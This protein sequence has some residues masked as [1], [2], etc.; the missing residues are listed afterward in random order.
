MVRYWTKAFVYACAVTNTDSEKRATFSR[1]LYQEHAMMQRLK[2]RTAF[3]FSFFL[4]SESE[5]WPAGALLWLGAIKRFHSVTHTH[6]CLSS[7]SDRRQNKEP[8]SDGKRFKSR[9]PCKSKAKWR[10]GVTRVRTAAVLITGKTPV[11]IW[12]WPFPLVNSLRHG[13]VTN[14]SSR[15]PKVNR[16]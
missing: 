16:S 5:R 15:L 13:N 4:S 1:M 11:L 14:A 9:T 6:F 10:M 7:Y 12:F 2:L 3:F 8:L